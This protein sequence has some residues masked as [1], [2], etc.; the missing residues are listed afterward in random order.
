VNRVDLNCNSPSI[1][2]ANLD[3]REREPRKSWLRSWVPTPPSPFLT[4]IELR[5][6]IE[7]VLS[8]CR[9]KP[10]SNILDISDRKK[11]LMR[12]CPILLDFTSLSLLSYDVQRIR[13]YSILMSILLC[14]YEQLMV[15]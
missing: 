10:A 12:C 6:W 4:V 8:S 1:S 9:T 3:R 15:A 14:C 5:Y 2:T 11:F 7:L 13:L